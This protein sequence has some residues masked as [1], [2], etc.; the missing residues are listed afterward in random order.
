[1]ELNEASK[2]LNVMWCVFLVWSFFNIYQVKL[3]I[4]RIAVYNLPVRI[5]ANNGINIIGKIPPCVDAW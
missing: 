4:K 5:N 1:M 2:F 3:Q